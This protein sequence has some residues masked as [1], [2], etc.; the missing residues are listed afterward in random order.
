MAWA[1]D[2]TC[3]ICG[4]KRLT[5]DEFSKSQLSKAEVVVGG[6]DGATRAAKC[7]RCVADAA[8]A[9]RATSRATHD[10]PTGTRGVAERELSLGGAGGEGGA[11]GDDL[12]CAACGRSQPPSRFTKTQ[13]RKALDARS[14]KGAG[15]R[16]R[17]CVEKAESDEIK[18]LEA[19]RE[20]ELQ[21]TR[22]AVIAADSAGASPLMRLQAAAAETAAEAERVTGLKPERGAGKRG[23]GARRG[24]GSWRGRR[25]R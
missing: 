23:R 2:L 18:A 4:R 19:R 21:A 10:A 12:E 16:C 13:A 6:A 20:A 25:G 14:G 22:A 3:L 11:G 7:R 17:S 5:A 8:A 24:R 9:E 1:G 15:G